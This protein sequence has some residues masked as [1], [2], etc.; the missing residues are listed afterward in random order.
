MRKKLLPIDLFA[1]QDYRKFLRDYYSYRKKR[2]RW[3]FA[4][5]SEAAGFPYA[6]I[7]KLVMDGKRNLTEKTI[8]RFL[9]VIRMSRAEQEYFTN[10]VFFNQATTH[11]DRD[12]YYQRLLRSQKNL[13]VRDVTRD[14]Y[15]YY[16]TWYHSVVRELVTM[17]DFNGDPKWIAS[18]IHP[19][20]TLQEAAASMELLERLGFIKKTGEH[21]W[22]QSEPVISSGDEPTDV[23]ILNYHKGMLDVAKTML[24][25]V[26]QEDRD[27][28]SLTL[29]VMRKRIPE[30]KETIRRFRKEVMALVSRDAGSTDVMLLNIQLMPVTETVEKSS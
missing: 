1:Y 27:V 26:V 2:E 25:E 7:Y 29:G 14:R 22:T 30:L 23:T 20:V 18:R 24:D 10:L 21:T 5:F 12:L 16:A 11:S 8:G 28:S 9:A 4:K 17:R 13:E 3:T 6:N 19:R 15:E